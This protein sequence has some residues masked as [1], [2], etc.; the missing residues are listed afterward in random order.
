VLVVLLTSNPAIMG[1]RASSP[2]LRML[3]W[4]TAMIMTAAGIGMLV[5][6]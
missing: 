4:A 5:T 6:L 2:L 1:T 3:G